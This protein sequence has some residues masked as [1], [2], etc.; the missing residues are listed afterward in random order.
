MALVDSGI[1][2]RNTTFRDLVKAGVMT[3]ALEYLNVLPDID[4]VQEQLNEQRRSL[5]RTFMGGDAYG[6]GPFYEQF[7][8]RAALD[9]A[10]ASKS[11]NISSI[12]DAD[13]LRVIRTSWDLIAGVPGAS[14]LKV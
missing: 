1:L 3:V 12:T 7:I 6:S 14:A 9:S 4:P 11:N 2:S 5:S 10:I 8:W 13:V